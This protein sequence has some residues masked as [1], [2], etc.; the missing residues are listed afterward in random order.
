[1][2][3]FEKKAFIYRHD[4]KNPTLRAE[5]RKL[6]DEN[7]IRITDLGRDI[8]ISQ[9]SLF[10]SVD[11]KWDNARSSGPNI[12]LIGRIL[13]YF[14]YDKFIVVLSS[15]YTKTEMVNNIF[16]KDTLSDCLGGLV[17]RYTTSPAALAYVRTKGYHGGR[18][19]YSY[20]NHFNEFNVSKI[21]FNISSKD[22]ELDVPIPS[23]LDKFNAR[24]AKADNHIV[25]EVECTPE[26]S[27][28]TELTEILN[29][30]DVD[31]YL[32]GYLAEEEIMNE[33]I[34]YIKLRDI[35]S[36]Y[37]LDEE[38]SIYEAGEDPHLMF[39]MSVRHILAFINDAV[40]SSNVIYMA[41]NMVHIERE[42]I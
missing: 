32:T 10:T 39:T 17:I 38:L 6:I 30:Y 22:E 15:D 28:D 4:V 42:V 29:E 27:D 5:L 33:P 35:L 31:D 16:D 13:E 34:T 9:T 36:V 20:I 14:G 19:I 3:K 11:A 21:V 24:Q 23:Q 40:L 25:T 26:V 41:A 8:G 18:R 1:M 2:E 12:E 7:G 37:D